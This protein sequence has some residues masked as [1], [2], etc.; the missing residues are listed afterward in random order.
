MRS[1]NSSK[2]DYSGFR[3]SLRK[4]HGNDGNDNV[5]KGNSVGYIDINNGPYGDGDG[6]NG[7]NTM[8]ST[9]ANMTGTIPNHPTPIYSGNISGES[10]PD[11]LLTWQ[12]AFSF[13]W[14]AMAAY[15]SHYANANGDCA[16]CNSSAGGSYAM[17]GGNAGGPHAM[18]YGRVWGGAQSSRDCNRFYHYPYVYYPQN[19][20]G[21]E[22]FRS[23]DSMYHGS[24]YM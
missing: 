4:L 15:T 3:R 13:S 19:F 24:D 16:T 6:D 5:I 11:A 21:D 8:I 10:S 2:R 7:T 23:S 17:A 20:I 14:L 18:A 22:Y 12:T 1:S 9:P